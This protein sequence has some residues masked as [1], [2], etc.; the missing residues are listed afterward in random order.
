M[1]A[2]DDLAVADLVQT[3]QG[4]IW[5]ITP[6]KELR[7]LDFWAPSCDERMDLEAALPY[8]TAWRENGRN[9]TEFGR[10]NE[11]AAES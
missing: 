10:W 7:K 11:V 3:F 2:L 5:L 9:G 8:I 6:A 1:I 4:S